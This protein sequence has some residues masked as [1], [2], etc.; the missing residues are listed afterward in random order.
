M[1]IQEL[2]KLTID[3][4]ASDLHLVVGVPPTV[5]VDGELAPINEFSVLTKEDVGGI[6]ESILS[7][8]QAKRLTINKE[9]DFSFA[10]GQAARF[11]VNAYTQKGSLAA[12]FRNI[13]L[14]IPALDSLGL[15]KLVHSFTGLRQGL[16][17]VT[18]PTGHGK[19]TTL[20]AIIDEI[21][22]LRACH[23]ITIEDPVEFVF[24]PKKSIISQRE[25]YQDTQSWEVSLRSALRQ[26]PDVVFIGEM[27]DRET[28]GSA[29]TIAETGHLVFATLH[30]NS[31]AQTVDRIVDVFP[32]GE[33]DQIKLQLSN[34]I[35]GVLSLRLIP[36][37]TGGRCP[38]HE[39]M[40]GT[41]AIRSA[42]R[43]GK[44]HQIDSIIQ[45]SSEIG[46]AT[47]EA[48]LANL[49]REEKV[50]L[51]VAQSWAQRPDDLARLLRR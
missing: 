2:L 37:T 5:R 7:A 30:T 6:L 44:T 17:L 16:I 20:A 13:P 4:K 45:T 28:I 46:M 47:L 49:V 9:L 8:E 26:D 19:S 38:A 25:M 12:S 15:P 1:E 18:G 27:R 35:E 43:E 3:K 33:Q 39:I 41:T 36:K 10:F 48:S 31:A 40:L 11:R 14:T 51:E 42:I 23:I 21:N 32:E 29:L 24:T 50:S 22:T 34:I